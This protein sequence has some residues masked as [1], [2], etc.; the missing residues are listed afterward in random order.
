MGSGRNEESV[1]ASQIRDVATG[2]PR[3]NARPTSP[4]EH[5]QDSG[6]PSD[7]FSYDSSSEN[8]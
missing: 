8:Q 4:V 1:N 3:P 7:E 5:G 2:L 6:V